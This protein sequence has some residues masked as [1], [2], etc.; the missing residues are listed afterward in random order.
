MT[1][2]DSPEVQ[3]SVGVDTRADVH[4]AG[5]LGST[6]PPVGDS[7]GAVD[8][9]WLPGLVAGGCSLGT[10]E[11]WGIEGTGGYGAWLARWLLW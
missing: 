2:L 7:V 1:A 4:V 3:V 9:S 11:R 6:R 8:S 10:V 5:A